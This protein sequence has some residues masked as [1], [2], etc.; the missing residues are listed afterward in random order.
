[1]PLSKHFGGK[2]EKVAASMKKEYG[3]DWKRVFYA[4]DNKQKTK[5]DPGA[6]LKAMQRK[7]K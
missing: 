1:M 6:V 2:G 4:T 7:P 3:A 5:H